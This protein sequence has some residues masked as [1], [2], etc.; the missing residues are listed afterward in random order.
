MHKLIGK[1]TNW[2]TKS[3]CANSSTKIIYT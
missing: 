2:A 3:T 1:I